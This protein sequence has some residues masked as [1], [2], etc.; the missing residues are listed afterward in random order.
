VIARVADRLRSLLAKGGY[1][2]VEPPV[3]QDADLFL[4]LAGEDLR[5]RLFLTQS[6]DGVDLCMRPDYTIPVCLHHL[7]TGDPRRTADYAYYGPVFRQRAGETGE[8]VQAGIESIGRKAIADA[9]ADVLALA[10]EAVRLYGVDRPVI[11]LGDSALFAALLDALALPAAW[12][13]RLARAFGDSGKL[14]SLLARLAGNGV[15]Q[16]AYAGFLAALDGADHAAA[17]RVVDDLLRLARITPVGG[18][19]AAEIA[20]RFLEQAALSMPTAANQRAARILRRYLAISGTPGEATM[21]IGELAARE[22]L[23]LGPALAR[24]A[25]RTQGLARNGLDA[26]GIAFAADFGRRLDYYTG[27]VFELADPSGRAPGPLAGGGRYDRL[28]S[29]IVSRD[30]SGDDIPAVGFALWVDRLE[31]LA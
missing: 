17:R 2:F 29:L 22:G 27:F 15:A 19:T 3:L 4:D 8:F 7:T 25:V 11:R 10:I 31:A 18:R 13:R 6:A 16:P 30:G 12:R 21:A 24:F 23:D 14:E 20:E 1:G 28:L 5:R 26:D 9:D